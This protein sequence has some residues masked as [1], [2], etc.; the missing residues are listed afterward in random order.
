MPL[1]LC[2]YTSIRHSDRD[3]RNPGYR[4]VISLPALAL[5]IRFPVDDGIDV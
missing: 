2:P 5:D 3:C 1:N 4:E